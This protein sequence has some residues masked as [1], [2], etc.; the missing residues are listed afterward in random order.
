MTPKSKGKEKILINEEMDSEWEEDV[1]AAI[2]EVINRATRTAEAKR[3]LREIIASIT[4]KQL[5][6][7]IPPPAIAKKTPSKSLVST[8]RHPTKEKGYNLSG[9]AAAMRAP[10]ELE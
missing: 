10:K 3:S 6:T 4:A 1:D 8:L 5:A 7:T 9:D 2:E